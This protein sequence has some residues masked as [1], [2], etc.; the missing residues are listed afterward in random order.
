VLSQVGRKDVF[1][2]LSSIVS[3]SQLETLSEDNATKRPRW[4]YYI[5]M[6]GSLYWLPALHI[7]RDGVGRLKL[8]IL[9]KGQCEGLDDGISKWMFLPRLFVSAT[10]LL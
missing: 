4:M 1:L 7:I 10:L 3:T 6:L 8:L 9:I 2:T 5:P